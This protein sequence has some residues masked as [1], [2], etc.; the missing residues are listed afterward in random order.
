MTMR[1]TASGG[2]QS[3]RP[4]DG[5][6]VIRTA[7]AVFPV[8]ARTASLVMDALRRWWVPR[9]IGFVDLHGSRVRV[10]SATIMMIYESSVLQ[11]QSEREFFRELDAEDAAD[12]PAWE[13]E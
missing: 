1:L 6:F 11:R 2:G 12:R 9:W 13:G 10:R 4:I 8:S 3:P 7:S 5:F